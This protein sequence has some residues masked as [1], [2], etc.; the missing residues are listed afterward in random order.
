MGV[1]ELDDCAVAT[2]GDYRHIIEW[3]GRALSHTVDPRHGAPLDN[4]LASVTVIARNAMIADA[5]GDARRRP[6]MVCNSRAVSA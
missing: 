2:S 4:D 1:I 3:D 6:P 5:W